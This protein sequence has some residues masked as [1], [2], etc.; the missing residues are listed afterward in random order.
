MRKWIMDKKG[1]P[2]RLKNRGGGD[3]QTWL[4]T[5]FFW[6]RECG[7]SPPRCRSLRI[8]TSCQFLPPKVLDFS[9]GRIVPPGHR[10]G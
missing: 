7:A 1:N 9:I 10:F 2:M 8:R 3:D 4:E 5:S 6:M